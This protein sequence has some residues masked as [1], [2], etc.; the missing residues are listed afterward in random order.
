LLDELGRPGRQQDRVAVEGEVGAVVIAVEPVGG[1]FDDASGRQGIEPDQ[2]SGDAY[3]ERQGV[4]VEAAS[5]LFAALVLVE[6]ARRQRLR[7]RRDG[8]FPGQSAGGGP[9]DEGGKAPASSGAG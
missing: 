7:P 5:Q 4:V 9:A 6:E 1:E 8:E 3:F 2:G